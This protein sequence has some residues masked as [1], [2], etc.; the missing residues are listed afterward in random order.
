MPEELDRYANADTLRREW[1]KRWLWR[2]QPG[3]AALV[4]REPHLVAVAQLIGRDI[5]SS[6]AWNR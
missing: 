2:M 5:R 3:A 6:A 4:W 1:H